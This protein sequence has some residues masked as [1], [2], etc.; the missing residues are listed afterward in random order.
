MVISN[1][2]DDPHLNALHT[3]IRSKYNEN[4]A[5][6]SFAYIEREVTSILKDGHKTS[7]VASDSREDPVAS[8]A[9]FYAQS[10]KRSF[11]PRGKFTGNQ[12]RPPI[13]KTREADTKFRLPHG[14]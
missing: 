13:T 1:L 10:K 4:Q 12:T 5:S 2:K 14:R 3:V 8:V 11:Q 6:I 7:E 9:S